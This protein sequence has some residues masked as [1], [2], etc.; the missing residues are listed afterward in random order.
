MERK[1]LGRGISALIP[2]KEL[3]RKN[4]II[5]VQTDKI[6][7]NPFQPREDFD[8]TSIEELAQ[9]I[10]EK[11]VIQPLLVRRKG[12]FYELIAGERRLRAAKILGINEL[13]IIVKDVDDQDSLELALIE[14][15]QRQ[16]LNPIEEAHAY[17]YLIDKFQVTQEKISALLGKSRVSIT[18]TLRLLKLPQEIK[19]EIKKGRISFAH[20]R[21]LLEIE[22]D[23]LKRLLAQETITKGLSVN[24]LENL[25]KS[26]RPRGMKR[27]RPVATKELFVA[28]LEEELQHLLSSKVKI[29]KG[30]KRGHIV[31]EFYSQEDLQRIV[32]KMKGVEK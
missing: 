18:N 24:E 16:D 7:P 15:V 14:N 23:N 9:S 6:K 28:M 27:K 10:K 11:G 26:K 2:E 25:I 1:A 17:Q 12:D 21:A 29:I 8:N 30:K 22:D 20:G 4:E 19:E 3:E 31:I 13:P 5:Y 32:N